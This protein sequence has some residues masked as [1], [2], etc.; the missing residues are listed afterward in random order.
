MAIALRAV[1]TRLKADVTVS[2]SPQSVSLPAGHVANDLLIMFVLT[3]ANSNVTT[4]PSGWT[5]LGYITNGTSISTPYTPRCRLKILYRIDNGSL[6][7]SV[8]LPF[9]TSAWPTGDASVLAFVVAYSGCDT[10]GPIERFDFTTTTATTQAQAHPQITTSVANDWLL[11]YR[12]CSTDTP[13]AT[14]TNSVGTDAE[15]VDDS[16]S[17]QELSCA[18]YDSNAALTAGLQTQRTTTAS[19]AATYGSLMVSIAIKPAAVAGSTFASPTQAT[20]TGTAYNATVQASNGSWDLCGSTPDYRFAIDWGGQGVSLN[21][22][23]LNLNPYVRTDLSDWTATSASMARVLGIISSETPV[24]QLTSTA[25]ASPRIESNQ[26][27]VVAGQSYRAYGWLYVPSAVP[28][29][30]E[31]NINWFDGAH[32]YLSTSANAVTIPAGQWTLFDQTFTAPASA[33]YGDV[34]MSLGGTPGAGYVMYGYGLM[35]IDPAPSG[36]ILV[37]GPGD[38]VTDDIISETTI[39]YGRDQD[40]QLSPA[41]VGS[42]GFALNNSSRRYSP[43]NTSGPL[44]GTL[45]PARP[46]GGQVT[47]GGNVYQLFRGRVDDYNIKADRGDRTVDFTFLDGLSLLQG[48]KLSTAVYQSLRTGDVVNTILDLIGWTGNRDIDDGATVVKFWW[49]E[50][51]DALSAVQEIVKSEGPPSVA[52]V[53]PDGTFVF[54]DRHHRLLRGQSISSQATYTASALGDCAVSPA[55][56]GFNFTKPFTYSH[57]WRDII[58]SVSFDVTERAVDSDVT[59]VWQ[60]QDTYTLAIGESLDINVSGSDP[61]VNAIVPVSGT[62]FI[63]SGAGVVSAAL[64]RTSGASVKITLLAIGGSVTVSGLQLRAQAVPALRT[65]KVTRVD[66]GSIASHGERTYPDPAPW[67]NVNDAGAIANMILLHYAQRRPTVQLRIVTSDPAHFVQVL[68]RTVSDRIHIVNG[69]MGLDDDFFVERVTHT[70]TRR[71]MTGRPPVHSVVLGCEKNLDTQANPFRFDVR[72]AGFDQGVFDPIVADNASTVF[73]F[74]HPTQGM[75][76]TG[77]FGT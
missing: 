62:D 29:T 2:G 36:A 39:T 38:D 50:G 70:I 53:A 24:L 59:A 10:S 7:S 42:A 5:L 40:R 69:E 22:L 58:N 11:T 66:A 37:P 27:P 76:D 67:A 4:D 68:Q 23:V 43:E 54:R 64:D 47:W 12:A 19:R 35:L 32:A 3:D 18:L 71:N 15:R 31:L 60:S 56:T 33:A 1:G 77:L 17:I 61:F 21:G 16:D 6:G 8:S 65:V 9:D 48:V 75:F 13:V 41:A 28:T 45:D 25:G 44:Y 51:T 14:Y 72:G 30:S 49:A 57:G 63:T 52:Y 34:V 55:V 74:D 73:I 20:V 26:R 46:A